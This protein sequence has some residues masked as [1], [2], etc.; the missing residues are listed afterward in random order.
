M[1]SMRKEHCESA[2]SSCAFDTPNYAMT[3]TSKVE[4]VFVTDPEGGLLTLG[5]AAWPVEAERLELT[6]LHKRKPTPL[7]E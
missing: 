7:A 1:A 5:R 2:D 3:T 4:W 6:Q